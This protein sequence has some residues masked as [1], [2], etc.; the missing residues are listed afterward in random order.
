MLAYS[1]EAPIQSIATV[2][3]GGAQNVSNIFNNYIQKLEDA[4]G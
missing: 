2:L 1:F 4:E 3:N